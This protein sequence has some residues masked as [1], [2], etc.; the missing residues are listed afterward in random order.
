MLVAEPRIPQQGI[1]SVP[2]VVEQIWWQADTLTVDLL[3]TGVAAHLDRRDGHS[4]CGEMS[5]VGEVNVAPGE[6]RPR[7]PITAAYVCVDVWPG[8]HWGHRRRDAKRC[9][10]EVGGAA[11]A[12]GGTSLVVVPSLAAGVPPYYGGRLGG[13]GEEERRARVWCRGLRRHT[14]RW[15]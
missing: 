11:A 8:A 14:G 10:R 7:L 4:I 6:Q 3:T 5:V 15:R 12:R 13:G 1:D 9:G 2:A